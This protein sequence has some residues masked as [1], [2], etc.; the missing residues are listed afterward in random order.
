MVENVCLDTSRPVSRQ[1]VCRC[2]HMLRC[3]R[4]FSQQASASLP[5]SCRVT[6]PLLLEAFIPSRFGDGA[7]GHAA[8]ESLRPEFTSQLQLN[9]VEETTTNAS[10]NAARLQTGMVPETG[11]AS[12]M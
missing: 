12:G 2:R 1:A 7:I 3:V 9:I 10:R 4:L 5:Y 11:G 8:S 6:P